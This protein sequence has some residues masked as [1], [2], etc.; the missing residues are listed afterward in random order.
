[1][2]QRNAFI[3]V[4]SLQLTPPPP[5]DDDK[6]KGVIHMIERKIIPVSITWSAA[7]IQLS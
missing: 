5:C 3:I 7:Q 1:L 6:R 2:F 4:F